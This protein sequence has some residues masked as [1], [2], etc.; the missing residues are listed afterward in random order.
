MP[1]SIEDMSLEELEYENLRLTAERRGINEQQEKI[2][3]MM[4]Q[5]VAEERVNVMSDTQKEAYARALQVPSIE[6]TTQVGSPG[7]EG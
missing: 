2:N 5:R 4:S 3:K 7:G 1:K 6:P